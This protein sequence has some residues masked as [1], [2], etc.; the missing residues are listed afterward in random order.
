MS[1]TR[2]TTSDPQESV[3]RRAAEARVEPSRESRD[4][5]I[6]ALRGAAI[7][8]VVLH[9]SILASVM[10]HASS[11]GSY[12]WKQVSIGY[13]GGGYVPIRVL[14]GVVLNVVVSVHLALFTVLAGYVTTQRS[15]ASPGHVRKRFVRLMVPYT[16]WLVVTGI[17]VK[18]LDVAGV[19]RMAVQGLLHPFALGGLWYL[20]ALFLSSVALWTLVRI[21]QRGSWLIGASVA[22]ALAPVALPGFPLVRYLGLAAYLPYLAVG[23]VARRRGLDMAI[24]K[25]PLVWVSALG[26][27]AATLALV[28]PPLSPLGAVSVTG[29]ATVDA[30]LTAALRLVAGLS[31]V[32]AA[33]AAMGY[34][35]DRVVRMLAFVGRRTIGMY[36]A[37][38]LLLGPLA[39]IGAGVV[40]IFAGAAGG[41]LAITLLIERSRALGRVLLGAART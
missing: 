27:F 8:G 1:G 39:A 26:I 15:L 33:A 20:Y 23:Y 36:A 21:S 30:V 14:S 17:A 2:D 11:A 40:G 13:P 37:H 3:S 6:D 41:S 32:V 9:H 34:A 10:S 22:L 18:G 7:L 29:T 4:L 25:R 38:G 5:R 28:W 24:A 19:A 35:G 12:L 16:A 31:G